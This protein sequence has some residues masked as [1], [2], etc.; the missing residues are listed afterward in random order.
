MKNTEEK[1]LSA[2]DI[3]TISSM[4]ANVGAYADAGNFESLEKL[5][6]EE[7][8]VDY[9]SLAGGEPQLKSANA[10]MCDWA[11][12]LPGFDATLH[13]VS[14][15]SVFTEQSLVV[16]TADVVATHYLDDQSWI[17]RGNY[18]YQFTASE[19]Q[20]KIV[21][22]TLNVE[23]QEGNAGIVQ[24]AISNAEKDSVSYLVRQTTQSVVRKYLKSLEDKDMDLL[25][26]VWADD[27]VQDMPYAPDGVLPKRVVGK[28]D[29]CALYEN[30][31]NI[32]GAANF[33]S[34]LVCYPMQDPE[35]V[36]VEF[37]GDVEVVPT[38]LRYKQSY[39]AVFNVVGGKI[40]LYR[41]YFDPNEFVRAFGLTS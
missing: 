5:F 35:T 20:W 3:A 31:P 23:E 28:E 18:R 24:K 40:K 38:G 29:I 8:R 1:T 41:E 4:V 17:V 34:H 21:A 37:S 7:V 25:A 30:W 39:G 22:T 15:I 13:A 16:A 32:T 33:T 36:F 2:A 10:L 19:G 11:N 12:V 27:A 9:T 14:N 6:H 26:S